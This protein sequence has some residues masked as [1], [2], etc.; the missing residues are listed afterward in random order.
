[1][2]LDAVTILYATHSD[3][4]HPLNCTHWH[5]LGKLIRVLG[6]EDDLFGI[7]YVETL[8]E[9][10]QNKVQGKAVIKASCLLHTVTSQLKILGGNKDA[11]QTPEKCLSCSVK[12]KCCIS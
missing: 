9:S 8:D 7:R 12:R 10:K 6:K 2:Q 4:Q 5:F 3:C 1:M 11:N